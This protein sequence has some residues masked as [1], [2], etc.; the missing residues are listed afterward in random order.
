MTHRATVAAES[1]TWDWASVLGLCLRETQRVLGASTHAD[2]A[3]QDAAVRVWRQRTTCRTPE[4]PD[5]WIAVIARHEALRA[6]SKRQF[7]PLE[8]VPEPVDD[9]P[10]LADAVIDRLEVEHALSL[11][12]SED[13]RLLVGRYW[14][15]LSYHE[16][17]RAMN[18]PEAT[19]GVRL[20]RL[21]LRLRQMV[22]N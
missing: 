14:E 6:A 2:D 17:S 1:S 22:R 20:H 4:R 18:M 3:A 19:V 7:V 12:D 13:R 5:P 10:P 21:R 9:R 8:A 16:L 11:L 15:D